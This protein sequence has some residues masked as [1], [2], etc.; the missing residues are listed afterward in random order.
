MKEG[1]EMAGKEELIELESITRSS[2]RR[3]SGKGISPITRS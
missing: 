3:G 2:W 1:S